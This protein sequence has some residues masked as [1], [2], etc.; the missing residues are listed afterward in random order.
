MRLRSLNDSH[1]FAAKALT[2]PRRSRSWISRS[3]SSGLSSLC[4]PESLA[5]ARPPLRSRSRLGAAP[6]L[7]TVP[8]CDDEAE[9]DVE[10][11]E[12]ERHQ[13]IAPLR[14]AEEGDR[15]G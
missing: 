3:S 12:P 13:C 14:R 11:A 9:E 8:P 4:T 7:A 10:P 6:V 2:I 1:S 5:A 15:A